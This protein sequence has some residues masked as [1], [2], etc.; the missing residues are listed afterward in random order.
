MP[1]EW[2]DS[3]H[4]LWRYHPTEYPWMA[5]GVEALRRDYLLTDLQAVTEPVG[6]TG[7]VVVQAR[8]CT[9]ETEWLS[10][11]AE[12]TNLIRGV[13]GWAPLVNQD[14]GRDLE[15]LAA[16]PKV[17]GMRHVLHD[18]PDPCYMC[19]DDFNCGVSLLKEYDLRYDVL[20]FER[21]LPQTIEFVDRHPNQVFIIDHVAKPRIRE[22][23]LS[24]W[25]E[26]M[27]EL[28]L[29]ENVYCK[30]SGMVTEAEWAFWQAEDLM[31]YFEIVLEAFGSRRTMFGSDWPVLTLAASFERWANTVKEAIGKFSEQEQMRIL[32]GTAIEAYGL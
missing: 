8:Q 10:E 31:P 23:T 13:I 9:Q 26:S 28:A 2:I 14:V 12:K 27:M 24:P 5:R 7:T 19:R 4:H 17:K 1:H 11:V 30:I 22:R 29:R 32:A 15:R 21:Q 18:E 20:I 3:H 6:I 16:L 25:R